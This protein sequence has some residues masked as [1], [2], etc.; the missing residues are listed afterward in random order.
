M[1]ANAA[2]IFDADPLDE[3]HEQL[4]SEP[5]TCEPL[6]AELLTYAEVNRRA[7]RLAHLL[8]R[9]GVGPE[10]LVGICMERSADMIVAVLGVLKAGA[11]YLPLDADYPPDRLAYILHDAQVALLL[12]HSSPGPAGSSR[13]ARL[14]LD[15]PAE[16]LAAE[17]D[18]NPV[19]V[20][21]GPANL[22]Y[23]IYTSGSTGRPKGTLLHHRGVCNLVRALASTLQT[24]PGDRVLQFASFSFD[25]S[26]C[27]TFLALT[28]GA[29]LY[30]TTR[31]PCSSHRWLRCCSAMP[32][33]RPRCR[34]RCCACCPPSSCLHWRVASVGE[35][36]TPEIVAWWAPGRSSSTAMAP[37]RP[38][39]GGLG[40]HRRSARAR[41]VPIG[42]PIA[43]CPA[44]H[45]RRPHA[46]RAHRRARRALHR[47]RRRRGYLDR[48]DLTAERFVPDPFARIEDGRSAK[49]SFAKIE[50]CVPFDS[51][52]SI[53]NLQSS[54]RLYRT[55]DLVRWPPD[56]QIEFM[57]RL[58]DQVKVRGSASSW[59]R[60]RA[61]LNACRTWCSRLCWH[62]RTG[63]A[64]NT[65]RPSSHR[66]P[67]CRSHPLGCARPAP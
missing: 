6:A 63:R 27:E 37:P 18:A 2:L 44:L 64:T 62:A 20:G 9:H 52:S 22:A 46:A 61:A 41:S 14:C 32:S 17:D 55:G 8:R 50:D 42:R 12:T 56:G 21:V 11:A 39:G 26:V 66:N 36:C 23:V 49:L 58:D 54:H 35:A 1:P 65:W 7:N 3:A 34:P 38:P 15:E 43:E 28:T 4:T 67:A 24:G 5:L 31:G 10:V 16:A 53:F 48:P 25:A 51:E 13:G 45:P 47:R 59:A 40:H 60:S 33:P 57:G 29:G 30:L 19:D